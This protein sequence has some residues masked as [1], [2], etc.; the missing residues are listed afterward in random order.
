MH[1]SVARE[2]RQKQ[3]YDNGGSRLVAGCVPVDKKGRRILLVESTKNDGEWVLPKGGWENDE[4]QEEA[5]ARETWEEAGVI[6]KIVSNLGEFEHKMNKRTGVPES[7]FIF[8]EMEVE[9]IE[10]HYPEKKKRA[11]RWFSFE[12]AKQIVSKK[13]MR[14]AL[15]QCS[16]S[17]G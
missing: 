13:V 16:L 3:L 11:R 6:G 7:I 1:S 12:D 14:K 8:F 17:R 2:G 10:E 5:A 9:R 4:S 15:E